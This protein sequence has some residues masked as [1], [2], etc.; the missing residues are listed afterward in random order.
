VKTESN[1]IGETASPRR[2]V[3]RMMRVLA[4]MLCV[5][6]IP[7]VRAEQSP[8]FNVATFNLRYHNP[9]DGPNAWPL[10]REAV[11][12]LI[13]YH[14]FDLVGTQ[15]GLADQIDDLAAM[16][17]F[18]Y[19]GVGRDDGRRAGEFAAIFYRKSRFTVEQHGDFWLSETPDKPGKGWDARCCNRQASW[20]RLRDRRTGVRFYV[21]SVHFD[22]EGAVARRESAHLM[23]R[24]MRALAGRYPLICLGDFNATP[25]SEPIAIMTAAYRDAF[26]I[27]TQPPYGP[28]GTFNDFKIDMEPTRRIDYLFVNSR[29]KVHKYATLTDSIGA[30]LPSD[31]FPVLARVSLH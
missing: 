12:A 16:T 17:E 29:V 7:A 18:A 25:E 8:Q 19:V 20:A 30:R 10:R 28:A 23:V 2:R 22:H 1:L 6:V 11:K 13:R 15:E 21:F 31:H 5:L 3:Y 4:A 24:K 27:S 14:E 26:T 9:A